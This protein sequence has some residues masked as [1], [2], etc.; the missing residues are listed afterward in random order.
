MGSFGYTAQTMRRLDEA[1][2]AQTQREE[3]APNGRVKAEARMIRGSIAF[4]LVSAKKS[5]WEETRAILSS[6]SE[7]EEATTKT[8]ATATLMMAESHYLEQHYELALSGLDGL[9]ARF[10]SVKREYYAGSLLRGKTLCRMGRLDEAKQALETILAL[11]IRPAEKFGNREPKA[12][13]ALWLAYICGLQGDAEGQTR[14]R[15]MIRM[16][17]PGTSDDLN[18]ASMFGAVE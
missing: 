13:A 4:E 11:P 16:E 3:S 1:W 15:T 17:Y 8:L 12:H 7:I 18:A 14:Y 2:L 5:T 6:V 10:P 9:F